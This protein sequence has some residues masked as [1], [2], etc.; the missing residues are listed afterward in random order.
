[1]CVWRTSSRLD[2]L[3]KGKIKQKQQTMEHEATYLKNSKNDRD[4]QLPKI[5]RQQTIDHVARK[6]QEW[7]RHAA[8]MSI[9][10]M[11]FF[12]ILKIRQTLKLAPV[13]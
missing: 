12:L 4:A 10:K 6:S 1:M 5:Q 2:E 11:V 8:A 3:L 13:R 9:L 7:S